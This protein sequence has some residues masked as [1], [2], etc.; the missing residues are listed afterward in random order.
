VAVGQEGDLPTSV[1]GIGPGPGATGQDASGGAQP[2]A[3][4]Q[5]GGLPPMFLLVLLVIV[6][7][8][9]TTMMSSRREKRRVADMLAGLKRGDRVQTTAGMIGTVHEVKDDAI[10]LRVDDAT[11]AKIHFAR[12]AV[13]HVLKSAKSEGKSEGADGAE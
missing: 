4:T 12:S 3:Q 10:V 8:I 1:P 13:A 2:G 5:P 11:G 7:M 9:V 6:F